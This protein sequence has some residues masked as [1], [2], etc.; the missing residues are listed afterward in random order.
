M[1]ALG[2]GGEG[3]K[4]TVKFEDEIVPG[5]DSP[6]KDRVKYWYNNSPLADPTKRFLLYNTSL[7]GAAVFVIVKYGSEFA[8]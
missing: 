3:N 6:L 2:N 5:P 7:F 4:R 8:I 1:F